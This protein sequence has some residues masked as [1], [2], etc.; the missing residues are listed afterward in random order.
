MPFKLK[1]VQE[2]F[3]KSDG[4]RMLVDRL[5]PRGISKERAHLGE[6]NKVLPPSNELRKAFH[7]G[8]LDFTAFAAAYRKE[9]HGHAE[10][11]DRVRELAEGRTV[12]LL[13][14]SANTE[15]NHALVLLAVLEGKRG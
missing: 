12:T 3:S 1:R 6:W 2:P 5:W 11:L 15:Q 9:L 10:E 7:S 14:A 8:Q 4:H 13:Y